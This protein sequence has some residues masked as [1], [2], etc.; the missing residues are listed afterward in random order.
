ML[1]AHRCSSPKRMRLISMIGNERKQVCIGLAQYMHRTEMALRANLLPNGATQKVR[2]LNDAKAIA[3]GANAI[4]EGF[5]FFVA[6]SLIIGETYRGSRKKA[7]QRDRTEEEVTALREKVEALA[8]RMGIKMEDLESDSEQVGEGDGSQ[9]QQPRTAPQY[10]EELRAKQ[11]QASVEVLLRLAIKNGWIAG[12]EALQLDTV[13]GSSEQSPPAPSGSSSGSS[14]G[15]GPVQDPETVAS[16]SIIQQVAQQRAR[17]LAQE[18]RRDPNANQGDRSGGTEEGLLLAGQ[19][20][21]R[22]DMPL[23]ELLAR[24]NA[25][26]T[27][28]SQ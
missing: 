13:L 26:Q 5:L 3:N 24:I 14:S 19:G 17:A 2:P 10:T 1:K 6:A 23:A 12:D 28:Q 8:E 7:E 11:L 16:P 27:T 15:P 4:S 20:P 9:P 25:Q 18:I 22:T 21:E